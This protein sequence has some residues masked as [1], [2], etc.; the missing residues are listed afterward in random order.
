ML[1][2]GRFERVLERNW[3]LLV[4]IVGDVENKWFVCHGLLFLWR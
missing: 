2:D 4:K 1:G 3:R